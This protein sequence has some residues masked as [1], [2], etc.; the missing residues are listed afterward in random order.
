MKKVSIGLVI[1]I[2]LGS[3]LIGYVLKKEKIITEEKIVE[4]YDFTQNDE[5]MQSWLNMH[6]PLLIL[7]REDEFEK[8]NSELEAKTKEN[9]QQIK[10][11]LQ[12]NVLQIEL[13]R[14]DYWQQGYQEGYRQARQNK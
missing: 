14:N 13:K 3:M 1:V 9:L 4:V 8:K 11:N 12:E 7:M 2:A 10:E 6:R 5:V